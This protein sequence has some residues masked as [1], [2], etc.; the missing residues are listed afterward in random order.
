VNDTAVE[1]I[2]KEAAVV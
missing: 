2:L 1:R